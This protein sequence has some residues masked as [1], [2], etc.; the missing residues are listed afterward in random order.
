MSFLDRF[1]LD[2][3]RALIT[4]GSRG[5][6]KSM[7]LHLADRGV[8]SI[9]TYKASAGWRRMNCVA[10]T[11]TVLGAPEK[12][13]RPR[14]QVCDFRVAIDTRSG[15]R[16]TEVTV[17]CWDDLA[18]FFDSAARASCV[19]GHGLGL[20]NRCGCSTS[21]P[22]SHARNPLTSVVV[23]IHRRPNR[24]HVEPGH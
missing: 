19:A 12:K 20:P 22:R 7:A 16:P 23:T 10:L 14:G 17:S 2:G 9:I 11:G 4:G 18:R 8:D 3:R 15:K 21:P 13:T 5:L 6:G 1:R 24:I